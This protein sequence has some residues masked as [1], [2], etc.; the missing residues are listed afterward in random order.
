MLVFLTADWAFYPK[1]ELT[2]EARPRELAV[3][4]AFSY[5]FLSI[6]CT[7]SAAA[8]PPYLPAERS[9]VFLRLWDSLELRLLP[10]DMPPCDFYSK[11]AVTCLTTL[12]RLEPVGPT[13]TD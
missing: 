13:E 3:S 7:L 1:S 10:R 2:S 12:L 5:C 8:D 4:P 9:R 11:S 6:S